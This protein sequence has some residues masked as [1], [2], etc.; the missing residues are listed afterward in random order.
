MPGGADWIV[1]DDCHE[2]RL[3]QALT[4]IMPGLGRRGAR[5]VFAQ[6]LV[7][8]NGRCRVP[9]F[10]V[11]AGQ[12]VSLRALESDREAVEA[13]SV[14]DHL[15][16]TV[17]ARDGSFAALVKPSGVNSEIVAGSTGPSV[18]AVLP[19]L[20]PDRSAILLNRL[21]QSVSGLVLVALGAPAAQEYGAWQEQGLVR[22]H[23][24][25]AV[26]GNLSEEMVIQTALDT[27]K[28]RKVRPLSEN[29]PDP[30]RWTRVLPL[31]Y[32]DERDESLVLVKILKGRRHQI[33][34]HLSCAGYPV[35]LDP[36]YGPG[37]DL[38][39][40]YLHHCRIELPAFTAA[41]AP[42]WEARFMNPEWT[43]A[44]SK[45]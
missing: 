1:P 15:P 28:R 35:V 10:R 31:F 36:L 6:H 9:G 2:W 32:S 39:W 12:R 45:R 27:A 16:I 11:Q 30:L 41:A 14:A 43:E 26:H 33:R 42:R 13:R 44:A 37:P 25:A 8:V 4:R 20:F 23:Y 38:G 17:A 3:D 34:A 40:I 19:E 22:K 29:E 21:D 5:R 18:E 7:L 24:L